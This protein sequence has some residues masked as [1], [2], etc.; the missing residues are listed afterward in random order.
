MSNQK[1]DCPACDSKEV[2]AI[3]FGYPSPEMLEAADSG[4]IALGGCCVDVDDPDWHCNDC[5][6]EW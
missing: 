6:H 1:P 2:V 5:E 4:E 3:M